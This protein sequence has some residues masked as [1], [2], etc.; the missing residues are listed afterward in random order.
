V[1]GHVT[2]DPKYREAAMTLV[3][4]HGY[5]QNLMVP[6]IHNGAGSGN[7]SDDEMA[8]MCF[9]N[10]IRYEQDPELKA[11]YAFSLYRYW[12]IEKPEVNPFFNFV[13]AVCCD[14]LEFGGAFGKY[15]L[16]EEDQSWLEESVAELRRMPLDR[17]DWAHD[18]S[19]RL[20]LVHLPDYAYLFDA[21]KRAGEG[22]RVDGRVF[23]CDERHFNHWN[24]NP[25]TLV[26]G[27]DGRT[28]ATGT[29]YLLPYYMGVYHGLI[30]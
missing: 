5:A 30:K 17:V 18:N 28:L 14:G 12:R 29:V 24:H 19:Y 15:P 4:E 16:M 13:Y 23:P 7:H 26:T 20:D 8:F 11:Q 27:G 22:W 2:G 1:A 6:K 25:W 21:D 3:R 9:Y 10:L